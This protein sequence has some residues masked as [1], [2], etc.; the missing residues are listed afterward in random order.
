MSTK[1]NNMNNEIINRNTA[2]LVDWKKDITSFHLKVQH[3]QNT[4][5]AEKAHNG[6]R[7]G[8]SRAIGRFRVNGGFSWHVWGGRI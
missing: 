4:H 3:N 7:D 6:K 5:D 2:D 8:R 1:I